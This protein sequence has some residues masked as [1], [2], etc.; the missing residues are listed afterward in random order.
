MVSAHSTQHGRSHACFL[1]SGARAKVEGVGG[2]FNK[3]YN[4]GCLTQS[5]CSKLLS[6]EVG[7]AA[8][9][10]RSIFGRQCDCIDAVVTDM[11][12]N[13]GYAGMSSF[14]KFIAAVKAHNWS[15]AAAEARSSLWC[16]QVGTRCTRDTGIIARGC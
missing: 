7:I 10:A 9:N 3:V 16:R 14:R 11:T 12:Y 8:S 13:L 4:G 6:G 5:Q 15:T 2:D 1:A